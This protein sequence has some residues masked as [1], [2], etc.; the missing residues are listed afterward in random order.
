[1]SVTTKKQN[2]G[3]L[4]LLKITLCFLISIILKNVK[5]KYQR[6]FQ[7]RICVSNFSIH[8]IYTHG[9]MVIR[10]EKKANK[11]K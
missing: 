4:C 9:N 7:E 2:I 6:R 5:L 10:N 3:T 8:V 1:M 11:H